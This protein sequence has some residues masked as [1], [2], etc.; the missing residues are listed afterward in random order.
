M[1]ER[2]LKFNL[3]SILQFPLE[4][5]PV[6]ERGLKFATAE[7]KMNELSVAPVRERGLKSAG[8][9]CINVSLESLP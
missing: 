1:R 6:R 2:G 7:Q 8:C 5:A 4:V 3:K 9:V